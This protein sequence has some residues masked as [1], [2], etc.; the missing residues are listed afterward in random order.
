[1][2][3]FLT[4]GMRAFI[5]WTG[6]WEQEKHMGKR[7][8]LKLCVAILILSLL[9]PGGG[10]PLLQTP[11]AIVA[12]AGTVSLSNVYIN[13][14]L[15][16]VQSG[17]MTTDC[18]S[19]QMMAG[20]D[21]K[22]CFGSHPEYY[23]FRCEL[24]A[25][26]LNSKYGTVR[27]GNGISNANFDGDIPEKDNKTA[28]KLV[29]IF[30]NSAVTELVK[31]CED[32][33]DTNIYLHLSL[34][35]TAKEAR[36]LCEDRIGNV[37]GTLLGS[38]T[39]TAGMGTV[40]SGAVRGSSQ[41]AGAYYKG[42]VYSSG[43]SA[44]VAKDGC[45]VYRYFIPV[46][47]SVSLQ[48]G[49]GIASVSGGG[50]QA[51]G[52]SVTVSA[53]VKRGYHWI[54]WSGG[55]NSSSNPY[56]FSMPDTSLSLTANAAANVYTVAFHGNGADSG[57]MSAQRMTYDSPAALYANAFVREGYAFQG[58][59]CTPSGPVQYADRQSVL[60]LMA[61]Q[62]ATASLYAQWKPNRYL[63]AFHANGG[64]GEM[65]PQSMIYDREESLSEHLFEREGYTFLGWNTDQ[66][67]K[68][69]LYEDM[70]E[71]SELTSKS[72][73][74]VN[75]YAVWS[76]NTYTILMKGNG[77]VSA[78]MEAVSVSYDT[79][80]MLPM[81]RYQRPGYMF[82]GWNN[83]PDGLGE[84]QFED[85]EP[86][87][88][89]TAQQDDVITLYACWQP[90]SYTIA[91]QSR[92]G[93]GNMQEV[94][95]EYDDEYELPA[96]QFTREGFEFLGWSDTSDGEIVVCQ[97]RETVINL[98]ETQG[99]VVNL[100]AVWKEIVPEETETP[101][102]SNRPQD[103]AQ[104]ETT[105]TTV[106]SEKPNVSSKPMESG[107]P[108]TSLEPMESEMPNRSPILVG[109][110]RPDASSLPEET[111]MPSVSVEPTAPETPH[112]PEIPGMPQEGQPGGDER[113]TGQPAGQSPAEGLLSKGA[114]SQGSA[115]RPVSGLNVGES[116]V[117]DPN[118]LQNLGEKGN[119][120]VGYK[121]S[122]HS[123]AYVDEKGNLIATGKDG[124]AS[125]SATLAD[126]TVKQYTVSTAKGITTVTLEKGFVKK[127][128]LV[129]GRKEKV[130]L[131]YSIYK[132]LD[133][134]SSNRKIVAVRTT[135][136]KLTVKGR[137]RGN[138]VIMVEYENGMTGRIQVRVK[139][140]PKKIKVG[141]IS[142]TKGKSKQIHVG[143]N[144]GE[145]SNKRIYQVTEGK[146]HI[147]VSQNGKI[148]GLKRGKAKV[149]VTSYNG[150]RKT[151]LVH[152][153]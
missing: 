46:T 29:N 113:Q 26:S 12:K 45:K 91:F 136:K 32:K 8:R 70:E 4:A 94:S 134:T 43:T 2:K 22:S 86:I 111:E 36:V 72:D 90:I 54:G 34:K 107:M 15:D 119:P 44:T 52:A 147:S 79:E 82:A 35:R 122:D 30:G 128:R 10:L 104:P 33:A 47:N 137:K 37:S 6:T 98:T 149:M 96:C 108:D 144:K 53:S 138:A 99:G 73:G 62:G 11:A 115:S 50:S 9:C 67:A 100:Y 153:R 140:A 95:V 101:S 103:T 77:S 112:N 76:Q 116:V 139:K 131:K 102:E 141:D 40:T 143:F 57:N 68:D 126:G 135:S 3:R 78:T 142:L 150:K 84:L 151:A 24:Y 13:T 146:K 121:S 117:L 130:V 25:A 123:V 18:K 42:Y 19:S 58:W 23:K 27:I 125:V 92:G 127:A 83:R 55:K 80:V 48:G 97:D 133:G 124:V 38:S 5:Q 60:N 109:S 71:V 20:I 61:E 132:Y 41:A 1:M 69:V 106:E 63:V 120:V 7:G 66:E 17:T 110:E 145:Y 21:L 89:L 105:T 64:T 31:Y 81:N 93:I 74:I 16:N 88:N 56:T 75:L 49:D 114:S 129:L 51:Y 39:W 152:I 14:S 59:S 118:R 148:V 65:K 28:F 85:G 87:C